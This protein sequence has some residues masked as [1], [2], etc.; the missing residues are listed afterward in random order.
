MLELKDFITTWFV[1]INELIYRKCR[2]LEWKKYPYL[3]LRDIFGY[4]NKDDHSVYDIYL[5]FQLR[6]NHFPV[7]V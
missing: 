2:I 6:H 7:L 5:I 1:P 3:P 4:N